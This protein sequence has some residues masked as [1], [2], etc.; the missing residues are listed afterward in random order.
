MMRAARFEAVGS[1]LVVETFPD[2]QPLAGEVVLKV[3]RCGICGTDLHMAESQAI[4]FQKGDVP[5][6]EFAGEVVELGAGVSGLK[7]GDRVAAMP[8][9]GCGSCEHCLA[10]FPAFCANFLMRGGA[11]APGGYAEYARAS[12]QFCVKLPDALSMA[13]G[14]L[15]E[16]LSVGLRGVRRSGIRTGDRVLVIGAG[17]IGLAAAY[18]ARR[19]GAGKV[20]VVARSRRREA[21]AKTVGADVF[22]TSDVDGG[23]PAAAAAALGGA[24]EHVIECAGMP[25]ML[26]LAVNSVARRGLVSVLGLCAIPDPYMPVVALS[27]EVDL[28]YSVFYDLGEFQ[29]SADALERDGAPIQAMVTETVGLD[30]LPATFDQLLRGAPQCK[31]LIDPWAAAST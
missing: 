9:G 19:A 13:D 8:I 14:A 2:P 11:M 29:I 6:H 23:V 3:G 18:W 20:A 30:Q 17:P 24:P 5:G 22:L 7:I 10:G 15:V 16:P 1:P 31:V 21:L 25:G 26:D 28:R 27:K 12:A 4:C